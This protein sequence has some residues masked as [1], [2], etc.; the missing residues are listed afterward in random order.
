MNKRQRPPIVPAQRATTMM[1]KSEQLLAGGE[2]NPYA[3]LSCNFDE[4]FY[5][6]EICMWKED[7]IMAP[8]QSEQ[9]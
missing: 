6:R 3:L 1:P 8:R 9:N 7:D 5:D 2:V 4:K